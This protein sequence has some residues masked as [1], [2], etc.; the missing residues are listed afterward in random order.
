MI[1]NI[2][3]GTTGQD[4]IARAVGGLC[5]LSS[6]VWVYGLFFPFHSDSQAN[7][8]QGRTSLALLL[9]LA[10]VIHALLIRWLSDGDHFLAQVMLIGFLMKLAGVAASM[11]TVVHVYDSVGDV[12]YYYWSAASIAD[13]H[14]LTGQWTILQPIWSTN[15]IIMLTS[16]LMYV[17]GKSFQSLMVVFG[18]FSY[19]GQY[20]F[21]KSFCLG[22]PKENRRSA[23]LFL[24][25][26]PSVVFW[27]ATIGK[28]A[29]VFFFIG[30]CCY[31]FVKMSHSSQPSALLI[32][33]VSLGGVMLVRPH[34][35][36]MLAISMGVAYLITN[37]RG[38]S[39][40]VAV[41]SIGVPILL[42]TSVYFV[43]Q[44]SSFLDLNDVGGTKHVL[45]HAAQK[46]LQV[47][48]TKLGS[49]LGYRLSAA[50][51][52]LFRP[53]PWEVRNPQMA[54]ASIEGFALMIFFWRRRRTVLPTLRRCR[55]DPFFLFSWI[56]LVQFSF[57]FAGA[58][59]NFGL[60][61]R[62][63]DMLIPVAVMIFLST[64]R[65]QKQMWGLPQHELS[66]WARVRAPQVVT[67]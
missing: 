56:Y 43:S 58:M 63:R 36:G 25:F 49:S 39:M 65:A 10:A 16:R 22:F 9:L 28:D 38:G 60:L 46:N 66:K 1:P 4:G 26:L 51:L 23:A 64:P 2:S 31:G 53:F 33:L 12:F 13:K 24:F 14:A 21:Y 67:S 3:Y 6:P 59:T 32:V 62:E 52:L 7:V 34:V 11:A 61:A 20:L 45:E 5:V 48:G 40:G 18:I 35:A 41:K 29:V 17:V 8:D 30:L 42:I 55:K 19:W 27:T 47:E 37:S 57:L 15:F 44:A 54:V 50:P